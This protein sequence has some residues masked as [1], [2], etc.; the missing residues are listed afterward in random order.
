M[1]IGLGTGA[2]IGIHLGYRT[3]TSTVATFSINTQ[4]QDLKNR[5]E[6]LKALRT[7][8]AEGAIESIEHGLDVDIVSLLPDRREDLR[9]PPH[10][11]NLIDQGLVIAKQYRLSYPRTSKGTLLDDDASRALSE[12]TLP[13]EKGK[14]P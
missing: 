11:L 3:G 12:I 13:N 14:Q 7:Q 9:I 8:D 2:W 1:L 6:A 5:V 4:V 10:T